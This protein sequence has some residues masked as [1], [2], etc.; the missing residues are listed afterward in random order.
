MYGKKVHG[1]LFVF[2]NSSVSRLIHFKYNVKYGSANAE[3][4]L[5]GAIKLIR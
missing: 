5:V 2:N 1:R 3:N 4:E